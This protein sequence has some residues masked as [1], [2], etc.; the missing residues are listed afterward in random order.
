MKLLNN[1]QEEVL[2]GTI[3]GDGYLEINGNNCRLQIQHSR[4]QREYVDW[5]WS[6]FKGFVK[7][8]PCECGKNDYRFRTINS[9]IFTSYHHTFYPEGKKI[10][11][12]ILKNIFNHPLSLATLYMD[13][14][15]RRPDCRGFF[16]DTMAFGI[17]GQMVLMSILENNFGLKNLR[18]HWNGD[19]H[20]IYVPAENSDYFISLIEPYIIPS[21]QYK[22]PL[23][24]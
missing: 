6:I 18:L 4:K 12:K 1:D 2:I 20:H 23:A 14:G 15:K 17:E 3:L 7:S 22:L 8:K 5:K 19:G 16:F 9:P 11:P 13:D 10:I 21:M 24:P